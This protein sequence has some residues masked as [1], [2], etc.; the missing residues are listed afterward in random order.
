MEY[1]RQVRAVVDD[2]PTAIQWHEFERRSR[3]CLGDSQ[4]EDIQWLPATTSPERLP[5]CG[6]QDTLF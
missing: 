5:I 3:E 4:F 2:K 1:Q 6:G